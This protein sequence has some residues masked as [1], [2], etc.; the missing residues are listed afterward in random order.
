MLFRRHGVTDPHLYDRMVEGTAV[1]H[2]SHR[3]KVNE[4]FIKRAYLLSIP[5]SFC[6]LCS[7]EIAARHTLEYSG[8]ASNVFHK[9]SIIITS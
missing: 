7:S 2:T 9:C 6:M 5:L 3:I 8:T 1:E 4:R